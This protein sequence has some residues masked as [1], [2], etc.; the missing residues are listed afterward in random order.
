[1][2]VPWLEGFAAEEEYQFDHQDDNYGH[3]QNEGASFL[4]GL[5][6]KNQEDV[7]CVVTG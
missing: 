3:L 1:M 6:I 2:C 4:S 5:R 7:M